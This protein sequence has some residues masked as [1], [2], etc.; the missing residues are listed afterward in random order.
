[1]SI[2]KHTIFLAVLFFATQLQSQKITVAAASS[3]RAPLEKITTQFEKYHD[4]QVDLIFGSSGKLVSQIQ[5]GA[6]FDIFLSANEAFGKYLFEN[7][8]S[9]TE[10]FAFTKG[11]L[12][13]WSR[14][15]KVENVYA[16]ATNPLCEN[17]AIANPELAPYGKLALE[18][19][20]DADLKNRV[21]KKMILGINVSHLNQYIMNESVCIAITAWSTKG[22]MGNV[23]YWKKLNEYYLLN[24]GT[25]IS[26]SENPREAN[27]FLQ[28]LKSENAQAI[29]R[30]FGYDPVIK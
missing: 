6:P 1:M 28:F 27:R 23:G 9:D 26:D 3:L 19:L 2:K 29:F 16:I 30:Q 22:Q 25:V 18:Y 5:N 21:N 17:V 24:T 7:G 11:Y 12:G 8:L 4:I 20:T 10:P 13:I 15:E 14:D